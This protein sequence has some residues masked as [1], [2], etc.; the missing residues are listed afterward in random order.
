MSAA[1][2]EAAEAENQKFE[3]RLNET[4]RG[5]HA[6]GP[7][8]TVVPGEWP[9]GYPVPAD[10][11]KGR[12]FKIFFD[13]LVGTPPGE[14]KLYSPAAEA[15]L[16]LEA[17][18]SAVHDDPHA[19]ADSDQRGRTSGNGGTLQVDPTLGGN[20]SYRNGKQEQGQR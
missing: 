20:R 11:S 12:A 5:A 17:R 14:P 10:E 7:C 8:G 6:V 13:P 16:D 3:T 19:G 1:Q 2:R 4:I 9:E 18:D 15:L